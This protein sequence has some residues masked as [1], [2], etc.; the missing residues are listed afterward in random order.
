MQVWFSEREL[1][2]G[3]E[4]IGDGINQLH[5]IIIII[6][7]IIITLSVLHPSG[8]EVPTL[9]CDRVFVWLN[10]RNKEGQ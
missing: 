9:W 2:C 3:F 8:R 6:I 4:P 1:L 10:L 7:I 5:I